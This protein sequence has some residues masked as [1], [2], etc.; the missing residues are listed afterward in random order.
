MSDALPTRRAAVLGS[1]ITHSLSPILHR[2]AYAELG[3]DW[4]YDA[5]DVTQDQLARFIESLGSE[6]VGLSL[7][8]PLKEAVIPL[9]DEVSAVAAQTQAVNTVV[10]ENHADGTVTCGYNTDVAG[11]A[12]ALVEG[13]VGSDEAALA[14]QTVALLGAGAT[15]RS[16]LVA[17][18]QLGANSVT[19]SA[20]RTQAAQALAPVAQH[21]GVELVVAPWERADELLLSDVLVSTLPAHAAD[22]LAI[23]VPNEPG[24]LLDVVYSPWP[25]DLAKSWQSQGGTAIGGLEMLAGQAAEQVRLMTGQLAPLQAMLAAGRHAIAAH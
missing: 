8:M 16:A 1:P 19:V 13:G 17:L 11:I 18:G 25:T 23:D 7:T 22:R 6:W 14:G 3:L 12:W 21:A 10:F 15:T 20:R 4:Q 5:I 9:L 24:I 2:A